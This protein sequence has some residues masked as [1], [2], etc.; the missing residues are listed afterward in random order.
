[1]GGDPACFMEYTLG[2]IARAKPKGKHQAAL[3]TAQ[4]LVKAKFA[5]MTAVRVS[6]RDKR[7]LPAVDGLCTPNL[8]SCDADPCGNALPLP[9][10]GQLGYLDTE[11][12]QLIEQTGLPSFADALER[13]PPQCSRAQPTTFAWALRETAGGAPDAGVAPLRALLLVICGA[14]ESREGSVPVA[15]PQLLV[16]GAD[17]RLELVSRGEDT[18]LLEWER[19]PEGPRLAR[20]AIWGDFPEADLEVEAATA[21][22]NQ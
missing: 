1:V 7:P 15:M 22:A 8:N 18:S 2:R 17:G 3:A 19:G 6:S 20:A 9:I 10:T 11:A 12:L 14:V 13:K 5:T 16:Y 4:A 21:V